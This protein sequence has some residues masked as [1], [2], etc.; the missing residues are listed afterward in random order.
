MLVRMFTLAKQNLLIFLSG[1]IDMRS[2]IIIF[3][4]IETIIISGR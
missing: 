3:Y 1:Y 2:K 4:D